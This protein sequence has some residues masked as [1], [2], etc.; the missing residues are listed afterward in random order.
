MSLP[1][2]HIFTLSPY[3]LKPTLPFAVHRG[4]VVEVSVNWVALFRNGETP[5]EE[6]NGAS[7]GSRFLTISDTSFTGKYLNFTISGAQNDGI[8][9]I[10]MAVSTTNGRTRS[11]SLRVRTVWEDAVIDPVVA[12]DPCASEHLVTPAA[13]PDGAYGYDSVQGGTIDDNAFV[14]PDADDQEIAGEVLSIIA[15][16]LGVDGDMLMIRVGNGAERMISPPTVVVQELDITFAAEDAELWNFWI[17]W[18]LPDGM[19]PAEFFDQPLTFEITL[20]TVEYQV[21]S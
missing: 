16:P 3:Q 1:R 2:S 19:T 17:R 7:V 13:L 11:R 9:I 10:T 4:D 5:N 14:R 12:V 15:A 8:A 6:I 18:P 20:C 21:P